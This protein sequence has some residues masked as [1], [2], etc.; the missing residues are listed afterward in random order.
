MVLFVSVFWKLQW[1]IAGICERDS[2]GMDCFF[3]SG[4]DVA[5][6]GQLRFIYHPELDWFFALLSLL[7][8]SNFIWACG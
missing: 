7:W 5:L 4:K 6:E 1:S 3:L 2:Y 8:T